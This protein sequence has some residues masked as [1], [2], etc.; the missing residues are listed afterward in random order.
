MNKKITTL[1]VFGLIFLSACSTLASSPTVTSSP[2]ETP[3]PSLATSKDDVIGTWQLGSGPRSI[4][5]QFKADGTYRMAQAT[6]DNL[7]DNPLHLGQFVLEG[8]L[9]TFTS[10]DDSPICAG[11]SGTYEVRL[12]EQGQI[13]LS[14]IEDEC[15]IRSGPNLSPLDPISP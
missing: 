5:F 1:L 6:A 10:S 12:L 7:N 3:E 14:L 11:Q 2:T 4:F 9:L 8:G 15:S 13:G